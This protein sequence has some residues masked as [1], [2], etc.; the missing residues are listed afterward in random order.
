MNPLQIDLMDPAQANIQLSGEDR[1]AYA[2]L[3]DVLIPAAEGMP[4][5]S[6]VDVHTR[7]VDQALRLRPD[8]RRAGVL[9]GQE[10]RRPA[11]R[12]HRHHAL[13]PGGGAAARRRDV[14]VHR[15]G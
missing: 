12:Q 9:L 14:R 7:W 6:E 11:G 13:H 10:R 15:R 8:L 5:A 3:A 1:A 2:R 4:S